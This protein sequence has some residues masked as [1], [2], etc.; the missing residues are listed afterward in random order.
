MLYLPFQSLLLFLLRLR[1]SLRVSFFLIVDGR[2][3][4]HE[5][6]YMFV[7][8]QVKRRESLRRSKGEIRK[9]YNGEVRT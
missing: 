4:D 7:K 5:M 9:S 1:L 8:L 3:E 2:E 6:I